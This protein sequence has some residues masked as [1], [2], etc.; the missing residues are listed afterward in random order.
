M[1]IEIPSDY[2]GTGS[3]FMTAVLVVE[4]ISKV[5]P[6]LG[7][8]VDLQNTLINNAVIRLANEEQRKKYLPRLATNMVKFCLQT[9]HKKL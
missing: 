6:S 7:V 9:K 1:G 3:N 4:E 5:D 8:L 2:G